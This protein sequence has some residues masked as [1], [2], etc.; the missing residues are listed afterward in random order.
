MSAL[1][2]TSLR[3]G[4]VSDRTGLSAHTL[5]FYEQQGLLPDA[6]RRDGSG[7]RVFTE[8][9]VQWLLV[10]VKMRSSGISLP[11]I[12][13]YTQLQHDGSDTV[14][15]RYEILCRHQQ[16]VRAQLAE[17]Q[18]VLGIIERKVSLYADQM[19]DGTADE[20][21]GSGPQCSRRLE[22][23]AHLT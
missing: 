2:S 17:L 3:I 15:E 4:Q 16:K 23:S 21:W 5:R 19:A 9:Q 10:C 7:H 11:D 18:Q 12:R 14:P 22:V 13:R 6:V 20:L 8:E 1:A